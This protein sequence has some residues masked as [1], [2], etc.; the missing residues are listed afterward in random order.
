M[1]NKELGKDQKFNNLITKYRELTKSASIIFAAIQYKK[2][3]EIILTKVESEKTAIL[4]GINSVNKK[5][6]EN[7]NKYN[8]IETRLKELIE[9]YEE[10]L[11]SL[12]EYQ[13]CTIISNYS[14]T[15]EEEQKNI[16]MM[17]HI[18]KYIKEEEKAKT[19]VDNSDDDIRE[20]ICNV[21]DEI[22]R[23]ETKIS[24][25]KMANKKK[26]EEKEISLAK[27]MESKEQHLQREIKGPKVFSKATRF[28]MGK[29]NPTK[30]IEKNVF[31]KLIQRMD[32]YNEN[33]KFELKEEDKKYLK[34]NIK[35][36]IDKIIDSNFEFDYQVVEENKKNVK[37]KI[38]SKRRRKK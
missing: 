27:A 3:E 37:R 25:M 8:Q 4:Y 26:I 18:Y 30:T 23:N 20:K 34:E 7:L 10:N 16:E 21:Q 36:T 15:I 33:V 29:I 28:F 14:K 31:S 19:K 24:R 2:S 17:V 12:G 1:E 5:V 38:T 9:K 35:E 13:D 6:L 22:T 32:S 11:K